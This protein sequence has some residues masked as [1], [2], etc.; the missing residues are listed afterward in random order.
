MSKEEW[1]EVAKLLR[2]DWD[3]DDF[4]KAWEEF[5]ELKYRKSLH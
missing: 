4:E 1:M 3:D 5:C 2:P